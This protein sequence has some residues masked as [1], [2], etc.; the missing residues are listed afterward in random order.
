MEYPKA[1]QPRATKNK[2]GKVISWRAM[3]ADLDDSGLRKKFTWKS[4]PVKYRDEAGRNRT[5]SKNSVFQETVTH[6]EKLKS[7]YSDALVDTDMTLLEFINEHFRDWRESNFVAPNVDIFVRFL[8]ENNWAKI[9]LKKIS[10]RWCE[11]YRAEIP[12]FRQKNGRPYKV[13]RNLYIRLVAELNSCLKQAKR[14]NYIST[15]YND[16]LENPNKHLDVFDTDKA[17]MAKTARTYKNKSWTKEQLLKYYP[18]LMSI[19]ETTA[20]KVDRGN[21]KPRKANVKL[22]ISAY[23]TYWKDAD[24]K[25]WSKSFNIKK[26]GDKAAKMKAEALA[27]TMS[28]QIAKEYEQGTAGFYMREKRTFDDIDVVMVRAYFTLSLHLGL[29]NGEI[30]GLKFSDFDEE[31]RTV[32]IDRQLVCDT[33]DKKRK[34]DDDKMAEFPPK[35]DSYRNLSYNSAVAALLEELKAYHIMNEYTQEDY[36]LQSRFGGRVRPDYWTKHYKKFQTLA[37]IPKHEQLKGTHS[38]RHT[39]ITILAREGVLISEL[40]YRAGHN[41]PRTTNAYYIHIAEDRNASDTFENVFVSD[42]N[43]VLSENTNDEY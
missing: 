13:T 4:F 39:H 32:Q 10:V 8:K 36:L 38:G 17:H 23:K 20:N 28:A 5:N 43:N 24:G 6:C 35:K 2:D 37:G 22:D 15:N 26:L 25:Y 42:E 3:F 34:Y 16:R 21:C 19:P 7:I 14:L 27:E 12:N 31:R 40:Q 11:L 9:P 29:R 33:G 1:L 41:D 30:C 18:M